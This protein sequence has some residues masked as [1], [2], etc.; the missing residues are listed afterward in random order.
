MAVKVLGELLEGGGD[1]AAAWRAAGGRVVK[2]LGELL[3]GG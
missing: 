2:L 3:G 1:V